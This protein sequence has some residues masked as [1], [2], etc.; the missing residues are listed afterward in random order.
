MTFA[1]EGGGTGPALFLKG[2]PYVGEVGGTEFFL[3][4]NKATSV[5]PLF[6]CCCIIKIAACPG[7]AARGFA[8]VAARPL[9]SEK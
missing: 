9:R 4:C 1:A 7:A 5:I 6:R 8:S 3:L 2:N